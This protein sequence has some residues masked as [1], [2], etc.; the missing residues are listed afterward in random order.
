MNDKGVIYNVSVEM[1]TSK[2]VAPLGEISGMDYSSMA[3]AP[4]LVVRFM[5]RNDR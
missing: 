2:S 5:L 4:S 3:V 1:G